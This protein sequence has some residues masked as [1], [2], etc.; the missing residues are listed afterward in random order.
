MEDVT[1]FETV[2]LQLSGVDD[3]G[4]NLT[5]N[6][7]TLEGVTNADGSLRQMSIGQ[8]CMAICLQRASKLET[9]LV[10]LMNDM[11][12]NSDNLQFLSEIE[13]AVVDAYSQAPSS[14]STTVE[15]AMTD[16]DW[17][18]FQELMVECGQVKPGED[19][20]YCSRTSGK[21]VVSDVD[22]FCSYV[23]AGMDTLNTTSQELLID[24]ESITAK[25][26]DTYT[27]VSNLTKVCYQT[28]SGNIANL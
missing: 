11:A 16:S 25:R 23:E 28:L 19:G 5:C 22:S 6:V 9:E 27:L 21:L 8:L 26:D 10:E 13:Q 24:I 12:T 14:K 7:Y 3:Y 1:P 18:R 20:S 15:I 17:K 4:R 2:K